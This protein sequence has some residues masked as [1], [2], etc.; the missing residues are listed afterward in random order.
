MKEERGTDT[1]SP[2]LCYTSKSLGLAARLFFPAV[3]SLLITEKDTVLA[4]QLVFL[5]SCLSII[6]AGG[7]SDGRQETGDRRHAWKQSSLL[8]FSTNLQPGINT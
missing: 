2:L 6:M 3:F 8:L 5:T 1:G 4:Q 7:F